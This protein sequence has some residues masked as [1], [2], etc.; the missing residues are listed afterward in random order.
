M[1]VLLVDDRNGKVTELFDDWPSASKALE[2]LEKAAPRLAAR[3]SLVSFHAHEGA[4]FGA[5]ASVTTRSLT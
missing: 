4:L 3:L 1:G 2:E 5:T